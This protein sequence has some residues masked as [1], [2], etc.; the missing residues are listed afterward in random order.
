MDALSPNVIIKI[1]TT[2]DPDKWILLTHN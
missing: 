2:C 1:K